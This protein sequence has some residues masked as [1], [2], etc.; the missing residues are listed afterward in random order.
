MNKRLSSVLSLALGALALASCG[1]KGAS[2][3]SS[4][5]SG[6][7]SGGE[8]S[9]SDVSEG[10]IALDVI[11]GGFETGDL[12]GWTTTGTAFSDEDVTNADSF[13]DLTAPQKVGEMYYAG[14]SATLPS[15]IGTMVSDPFVLGGMGMVTLKMGAMKDAANVYIEFF[16]A[17]D[18]E[19]ATPLSF[20][21]NNGDEVL[22]KLTNDD[23]D[24]LG[25]ASQLIRNVVDLRQYAG[26]T[27]VIRVTD[28]AR[29]STYADYS[30]A[31]LDDI[32]LVQD[33][34]DMTSLLTER[35]DQLASLAQEPIDSNPPVTELRNGG[36]ESGLDYW[37]SIS[38]T[39]FRDEDSVLE[40]AQGK[41]WAI[42]DYFGEGEKMLTSLNAGEELTGTI[43]SEK[44]S[45]EDQGDGHSYATFLMGAARQSSCYVAVNDGNTGAE[46][47]RQTNTA[48]SDPAL[49]QGMVRYY[50]DLS[51]YIGDTLY[52][53]IVD[54]ATSDGFAFIQADDSQINL[55]G[56]QVASMVAESRAWAAE[57]PDE[58]AKAAY[59]A[60]Y[61]GGI[62]VPLAGAAPSFESEGE[63]VYEE[64]R[65]PG[66]YDFS[67]ILR[68]LKA[69]D[70][71]TATSEI[72][73]RLVSATKDGEP[74]D[75]ESEQAL[76]DGTYLVTVSA[77][78][79]FGLTATGIA[80]IY[81]SE[82]VTIPNSIVNGDFE[83]G[84]LTGWSVVAGAISESSA[85]S[86]AAVWWAEQVPYNQG[87]NY[88]FDG[89]AAQSDEGATYTLRS[90]EFQ[91]GGSGQISFKMGGN[92]AR[93]SVYST[94][95]ELIGSYRNVGFFD[96]G[97]AYPCVANGSR[98]ATMITYVA[99]LSDHIGETLYIEIADTTASGWAV[100]FFDDIVTY[101]ESYVD[102][103]AMKDTVTEVNA[104]N[105]P[106]ESR[107]TEIPWM[108]ASN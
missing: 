38:G 58:N 33:S 61:N 4:S 43:R 51:E 103:T 78:D 72:E 102:Y 82:E 19:F 32:R 50:F 73:L 16:L 35:E 31:N 42:R 66:A 71:Y 15:F 80:R 75:L 20:T 26:E 67:S 100:A 76:T 12:T 53:T 41:Y 39:V 22:T 89:W 37:A 90:S 23:F 69:K 40:D 95:G 105:N 44:F 101:Y 54:N 34:A 98:L 14:G 62:S 83:T 88:H 74:Y 27:I 81:V 17:S 86:S 30:F 91:L 29:G 11:N 9:S 28:N 5:P 45:V 18:K 97:V 108:E 3:S 2:S 87:G 94:S 92:A 10:E 93:V 104:L 6:T 107:E 96:G 70:D 36:F 99:D 85:V 56:E 106:E 48:F 21:K 52:F 79:A 77:T 1:G 7:G 64:S 49:A 59:I 60:A 68:H 55:P 8:G 47:L 57:C 46:L 13:G 25:I 65:T 24:G 84:D 63:Y